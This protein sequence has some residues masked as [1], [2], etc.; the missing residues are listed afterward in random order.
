MRDG[1]NQMTVAGPIGASS[2]NHWPRGGPVSDA[3]ARDAIWAVIRLG[4]GVF[5]RVTN[6]CRTAL[7]G[8]GFS[9][10]LAGQAEAARLVVTIQGV[11]S[12]SGYV[13]VALLTKPEGFPDGNYS[14]QH[15]KVKAAIGGLTVVFDDIKAGA[16]A[17]GAY[18]DENNNGRLDTNILGYPI[19]GYAL[20]NGI[21][22]V[23][24]RPRFADAA[25]LVGDADTYVTLNIEY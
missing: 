10:T 14:S 24:T 16:Y 3:A 11:R 19:E 2:A 18:H 7:L 12:D 23:I 22:A 13:F 15:T 25:F 4:C 17:A 20:S 21:R 9:L 6:P 5:R 1:A 8:L